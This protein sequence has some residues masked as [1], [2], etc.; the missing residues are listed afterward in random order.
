MPSSSTESSQRL[1]YPPV[2]VDQSIERLD[3]NTLIMRS[4]A[5][6]NREELTS[7]DESSYEVVGMGDSLYETS[8]DEGH[9]ASVASTTP[10]DVSVLTDEEDDDV[11][12]GDFEQESPHEVAH[13]LDSSLTEASGVDAAPGVDESTLTEVPYMTQS[14]DRQNPREIHMQEEHSAEQ[15]SI[16]AWE[17]VKECLPEQAAAGVWKP[18]G[19]RELRLTARA[20]LSTSYLPARNSF[21]ILFVG[22]LS[23]WEKESIESCIGKALDAS[24]GPSRSILRDGQLEAYGPVISSDHCKDVRPLHDTAKATD[25]VVT[26]DDGMQL[27]FGSSRKYSSDE[28]N[29]VPDLV[30]FWYPQPALAAP[31]VEGFPIACKAFERQKIS[32]L[33]VAE[34]RRYHLKWKEPVDN[35]KNFRVCVEGKKTES[36]EFELQETLQVDF[37]TLLNLDPSQL[38]RHLA[39]LD[40]RISSST[41]TP[42]SGSW[43]AQNISGKRGPKSLLQSKGLSL[44]ALVLGLLSIILASYIAPGFPSMAPQAQVEILTSE[45]ASI[46]IPVP[47]PASITSTSTASSA[48]STPA[49]VTPRELTVVSPPL[50]QSPRRPCRKEQ[51]SAGFAIQTTAEHQFVLVPTKD[52]VSRKGKPQLQIQVSKDAESI[53][54]RYTRTMQGAYIVD[55]EQEYPVSRFNVS[56]AT[57]SKPLMQQSF[58]ISMGHNKTRAAQVLDL[59]KRDIAATRE[60][61]KNFYDNELKKHIQKSS[62]EAQELARRQLAISTSFLREVTAGPWLELRKATAPIRTSKAAHRARDNAFQIRCRVEEAMGLSSLKVEGKKSRAC[63]HVGR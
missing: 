33:H 21:K 38:N 27:T 60:G 18:Y 47:T 52:F 13:Q 46:K 24:P 62:Q 48:T 4:N 6:R 51:K 32:C 37:F 15:D 43:I 7:L 11:D 53:P 23:V 26:F 44:F 9:T 3:L 42:V 28:S 1:A 19:C 54:I 35:S 30:I 36:D 41:S 31:E 16:N 2:R 45:P 58:A 61:L 34:A 17:V 56:I 59:F 25:V 22:N 39:A 20:A 8:D 55:L 63:A 40:P 5:P 10:D 57:H 50:Q 49:K 14:G 29:R 12:D